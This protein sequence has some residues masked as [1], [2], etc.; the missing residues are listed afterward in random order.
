MVVNI[1]GLLATILYV[2]LSILVTYVVIFELYKL[3]FKLIGVHVER[4][5]LVAL[6]GL[7]LLSIISAV[8]LATQPLLEKLGSSYKEINAGPVF[9]ET[10]RDFLSVNESPPSGLSLYSYLLIGDSG[11]PSLA[12][13]KA[14]IKAYIDDFATFR[15]TINIPRDEI[16]GFFVFTLEDL[17]WV[18][19]CRRSNLNDQ[20]QQWDCSPKGKKKVYTLEELAESVLPRL[21]YQRARRILNVL[22]ENGAAVNASGVYIVS[23]FTPLQTHDNVDTGHLLVQDLSLIPPDYVESWVRETA[24]QFTAPKY[25]DANTMSR[26]LLSI[27]TALAVIAPSVTLTEKAIGSEVGEFLLRGNT[28]G[29][30]EEADKPPKSST[31]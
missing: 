13:N 4:K 26:V 9:R 14:A 8:L 28:P 12:R 21:D 31:P 25:W 5:G 27:R 10:A 23:Y 29:P 17:E 1:F 2:C 16:N 6:A 30:N 11:E 24:K 7:S 22:R 20:T 18:D 3:I 15:E 19:R